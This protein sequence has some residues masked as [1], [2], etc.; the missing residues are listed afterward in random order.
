MKK[1]NL[2]EKGSKEENQKDR[3]QKIAEEM[4][5]MEQRKQR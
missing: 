5:L 3:R 4:N 1:K 2:E